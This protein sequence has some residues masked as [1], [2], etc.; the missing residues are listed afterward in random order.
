MESRQDAGALARRLRELRTEAKLTQKTVATALQVST[1]LVSSWESL[2]DPAEPSEAR[3]LEYVTL[4][5]ARRVV[6]EDDLSPDERAL[7]DQ[8]RDELVRLR[9]SGVSSNT[10]HFPDGGPVR[11]ICGRV[12]LESRGAYGDPAHSNYTRMHAMADSDALIELFGHIRAANP[13]AD[14]RF[15]FADEMVQDDLTA[16]VVLLGGMRLN[17]AAEYFA[18]VAQLPLKQ[19]RHEDVEGGEVFELE[20][21]KRQFL[22]TFLESDTSLGLIEDVALFARLPNPHFLG[23]TLTLCSGVFARGVVGAVRMLTDAQLRDR[24][25]AYLANRF[26]GMSEYGLLLRVPVFRGE[27]STPDLANDHHRLFVW[28]SGEDPRDRDAS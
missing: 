13:G 16:H 1:P 11:L 5:A 21:R 25:E 23:R 24:N 19:V 12:P 8:L 10:W 14:V 18:R 20:G 6:T 9:G 3:L 26:A 27:S 17:P 4:L 2:T 28:S 7:R 22:P 15:V